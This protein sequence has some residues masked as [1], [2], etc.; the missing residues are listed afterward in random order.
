M[1]KKYDAGLIGLAVMG[2]NLALNINDHGF[3]I[4]VYNR[5]WDKTENFIKI[6]AA[7]RDNVF[8]ADS[9]E[10]FVSSLKVPRKIILMVKAGDVVDK[11]ISQLLPL[12]EKKDIIIDGGNSR[13]TDTERRTADLHGKG[14]LFIGAGISGGEEGARTGPSIMPGGNKE[15]WPHAEKILTSIAAR[16]EEGDI[17]CSW[18]GSGGSGHYVKMVHNGIEYGDMQLITEAYDI[19]KN[20]LGLEN[21]EM[22][23]IF[24]EW[25]K[26]ELESYLIE[27]TGEI[28]SYRENGKY[29]VDN[30]LDAAEQKGTGKWTAI[31][32]F[33]SAVPV[34]LIAEAVYARQVSAMLEER[35]K[36]S[37]VFPYKSSIK[38]ENRV[39]FIENIRQA[40][41]CSKIISYAQ[42]FML[43]REASSERKWGLKFGDIAL[44]WRGGCIIRSVF[45]GEIKKAFEKNP[46]LDNLIMDQYFSDIIK[47]GESAWRTVISESVK[48]GI[49]VPALSSA[50]CFYDSYR[51][52][53]LPANLLQAQRDY[54]GAHTF[55]RND[56]PRG[57][58]FH[59][60]WGKE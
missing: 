25:N 8:G 59:S 22:A 30:V 16:T 26:G 49:P 7:G 31:E 39:G 21:K 1:D 27:I 15:A 46:D 38:P 5:T 60:D 57:E 58:Y 34:T 19:M 52:A 11:Y 20:G 3:S 53:Q 47:K 42:G 2:S 29:L 44:M 9:L 35:K 14:I 28:L 48:T 43:L 17:C 40:L 23:Q 45:L 55:E 56:K 37:A 41:L 18:V 24:S 50:L 6:D 36:A 33:E 32:S 12:L 10:K 4:A 54:F 51:R 13:F